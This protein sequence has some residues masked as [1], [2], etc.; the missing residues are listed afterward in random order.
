[1]SAEVFTAADAH[2]R[3]KATRGDEL[4]TR[5]WIEFATRVWERHKDKLRAIR[6][7]NARITARTSRLPREPR[8]VKIISDMGRTHVRWGVVLLGLLVAGTTPAADPSSPGAFCEAHAP[9]RAMVASV[10]LWPHHN[11]PNDPRAPFWGWYVPPVEVQQGNLV[12]VSA[13]GHPVW[14]VVAFTEIGIGGR[15]QEVNC[16]THPAVIFEDGFES[17]GTG[18]WSSTVGAVSK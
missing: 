5:A 18:A 9:Y 16:G 1:M 7:A 8:V 17:G 15:Y 2:R 10:V 3:C 6:S 14:A 11:P 13:E 4:L 12:A